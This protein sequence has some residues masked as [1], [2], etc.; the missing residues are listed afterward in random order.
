M[1]KIDYLKV[2]TEIEK[3]TFRYYSKNT[4]PNSQN[5]NIDANQLK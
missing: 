1:K 5:R 2:T 3:D 4:R